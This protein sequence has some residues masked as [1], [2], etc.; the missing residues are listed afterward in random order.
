MST[1]L[2]EQQSSYQTQIDYCTNYIQSRADWEF[3]GM[4][5][6]QVHRRYPPHNWNQ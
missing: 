3:V 4:Y 5:A 2:E 6:I 1:D